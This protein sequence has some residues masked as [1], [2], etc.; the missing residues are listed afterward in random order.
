M[1]YLRAEVL[2]FYATSQKRLKPPSIA[3]VEASI[4][5]S[6]REQQNYC[7]NIHRLFSPVLFI[8]ATSVTKSPQVAPKCYLNIN[9]RGYMKTIGDV[10]SSFYPLSSDENETRAG[11]PILQTLQ[12]Y[13]N[14]RTLHLTELARI[15]ALKCVGSLVATRYIAR[16]E[17]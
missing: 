5:P 8:L 4:A 7:P 10:R 2:I 1:K 15:R 17:I 6:R 16:N 13:N 11:S 9:S 14:L 12:Y 3:H